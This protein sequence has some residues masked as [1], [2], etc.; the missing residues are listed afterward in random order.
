MNNDIYRKKNKKKTESIN[1]IVINK[2]GRT[3][4][5]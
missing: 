3:L 1:N 5:K 4:I 2:T